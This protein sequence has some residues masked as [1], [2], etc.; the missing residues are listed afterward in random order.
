MSL[1]AKTLVVLNL[2]LAVFF[3]GVSA[4]V[5]TTSK[6]WVA[7]SKEFQEAYQEKIKEF[8]GLLSAARDV[9][10]QLEADKL[11]SQDEIKRLDNLK[12]QLENTVGDLRSKE[13]KL[14]ASLDEALANVRKK[15]SFI[16]SK[17]SEISRLSSTLDEAQQA[18]NRAEEAKKNAEQ[19]LS[20]SLL[21]K[22]EMASQLAEASTLIATLRD[23]AEEKGNIL[24]RLRESGFNFDTIL[25]KPVPPAI[26]GQV[27]A[28]SAEDGLIVMSVGAHDKVEPGFEFSISRGSN[29]IGKVEVSRVTDDMAGAKILWLADGQA[30]QVGDRVRTGAQ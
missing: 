24:A 22:N 3:L 13:A 8:D 1:L 15:D 5:F 12:L 26:D 21:D 23:D 18:L 11:T 6:N 20:R 27:V 10:K 16:E 9:R 17:D 30:P 28:V 29:F 2:I 7:E 14:Q 19:L 25:V 4:T